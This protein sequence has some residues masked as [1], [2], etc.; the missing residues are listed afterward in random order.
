MQSKSKLDNNMMKNIDSY[1]KDITTID[2]FMEAVRQT[3]GM[4]IGPLNEMG[5]L[6]MIREVFQNALDQLLYPKSPCSHVSISYDERTNECSVFDDGLGI[7]FNDIERIFTK[8]HTSKNYTKNEGEYSSGLNG[9]GAKATNALSDIFIVRSY[10]Y[11]GEA[12]EAVFKKGHLQGKIKNIQNKNKIQGTQITFRP[13]HSIMGETPLIWTELYNL[14]KHMVSL[15]PIGTAIAF[16]AIDYN[17]KEYKEQLVNEDGIITDLIMKCENPIIKPIILYKDTGKHMVNVAFCFDSVNLEGENI[18]AFA[19]LCPTSTTIQNTHVKGFINGVTSWFGEYMNKI[20]LANMKVKTKVIPA[21]IKAGLAAMISV[22]DLYPEFTGQAKEL[23]SNAD[24]EPFMKKVVLDGLDEWSKSNPQEL[25]KL[26]KFFKDIAEIRQKGDKE[27][28]KISTKYNANVLTGLPDKYYK[29]TTKEYDK[30]ELIIVEGDSAGGSAKVGRDERYQGIFPIRGKIINAFTNSNTKLMDNAEVQGLI[31][32]IGGD[33]DNYGKR[34]DINKVKFSKIIFMADADADGAHI[35]A[36]LLRLFLILFPGLI[37]AGKVYKAMPPLYGVKKG[38]KYNYFT[39]RVDFVRYVQDIFSKSNTVA[40]MNKKVLS[41]QKVLNIL[42]N[43]VDYSY[44]VD[45]IANRYALEPHLIE[46]ILDA[47]INHW[48]DSKL[49]KEIKSTYRFM[50]VY[51]ENSTIVIEG[52]INMKFN[53]LYYAE[54]FIDDCKRIIKYINNSDSLYYT[55][56]GNI[57]SLYSLM[58]EFEKSTPS[59]ITRFKGL[60]EMDGDMLSDAALKPDSDRVLVQ[61]H[62]DDIKADIAAIRIFESDK[63]KILNF[64]GSVTRSDLID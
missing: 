64:V 33:K 42:L 7:P 18:T 57:V 22:A 47:Y 28:V 19:N 13:D 11:S 27:K 63:K 59:N 6:N 12:K 17:G 14:V 46:I 60:G 36:L 8:D 24:M 4:F 37:E 41:K 9:V 51:K 38:N 39:E 2:N 25:Q 26:S 35:N 29:P 44:E 58:K 21:D 5:L 31:M 54:R 34:F 55:L 56:N 43:N 45:V 32:I 50:D 3:P 15:L 52:V 48:P 30:Y 1:S 10:H 23:F 53:T 40:D 61:Y 62:T 20:Y 16:S 49:K